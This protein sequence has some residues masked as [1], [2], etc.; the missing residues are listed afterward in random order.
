MNIWTQIMIVPGI[1]GGLVLSVIALWALFVAGLV[2]W[3]ARSPSD[4]IDEP[5][6]PQTVG[7]E[8]SYSGVVYSK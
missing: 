6:E 2:V 8:A 7:G 5:A 1:G 3:I 4:S